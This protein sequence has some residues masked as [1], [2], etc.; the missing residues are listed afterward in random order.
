MEDCANNVA[1]P[2]T[3]VNNVAAATLVS[4]DLAAQ[5]QLPFVGEGASQ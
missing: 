3:H 1:A 2:K 5:Y 4:F